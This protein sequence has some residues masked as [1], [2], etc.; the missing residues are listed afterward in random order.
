M[1]ILTRTSGGAYFV[2]HMAV[3]M[4]ELAGGLVTLTFVFLTHFDY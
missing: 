3:F 1:A 4:F 2:S